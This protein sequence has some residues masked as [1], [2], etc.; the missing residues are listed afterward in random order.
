MA[1][2]EHWLSTEAVTAEDS[3]AVNTV[4]PTGRGRHP[5]MK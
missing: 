2:M 5:P 4:S 3:Q 1:R